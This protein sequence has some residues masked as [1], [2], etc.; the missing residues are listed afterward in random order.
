MSIA[1]RWCGRHGGSAHAS[2]DATRSSVAALSRSHRHAS[3]RADS[4][5][6]AALVVALLLLV[7][8]TL[9]ATTGMR[10]S[11]AELWMSGSEQFHRRAVEAASAGV[12]AGIARV[13]ASRG[14][15]S[16]ETSL[17]GGSATAP[18]TATVRRAGTEA[19]LPGSSAEKFIG[20]HF[21]I[22]STGAASRGA[23][24]VQVQG[25][26]VISSRNGVRTFHRT[27][28]GLGAEAGS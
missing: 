25:V 4:Q 5:R 9:L 21:E 12:E 11:V 6:G 10:T 28:E 22:E 1:S 13:R 8:L 20:E 15:L 24:D 27:G 7:I 18:Y 26:M 19:S 2:T 23:L 14:N 17:D 3:Q 16:A